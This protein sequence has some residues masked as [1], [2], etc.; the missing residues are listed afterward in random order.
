VDWESRALTEAD[1]SDLQTYLT[2]EVNDLTAAVVWANVPDTNITES[3]V[4]QHQSALTITES[5]ISD[6]SHFIPTDLLTD[7]GFVDNS[8][9]WDTAFSWGDHST[10]G[11]ITTAYGGAPYYIVAANDSSAT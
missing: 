7:Y 1:I 11:Y 10:V 4:V 2:T 3:S 6:L 5:Q 9:D 8:I